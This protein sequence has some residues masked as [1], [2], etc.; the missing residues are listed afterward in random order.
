M[1][2]FP[3]E[4]EKNNRAA[5]N[6]ASRS[7]HAHRRDTPQGMWNLSGSIPRAPT[8]S[9]PPRVSL[10]LW[11]DGGCRPPIGL[12]SVLAPDGRLSHHGPGRSSTVP[13]MV[14]R[15]RGV[16]TNTFTLRLLAAPECTAA[17]ASEPAPL[18]SL[19]RH[20][21][22][23]FT[24]R[25]AERRCGHWRSLASRSDSRCRG[26][27]AGLWGYPSPWSPGSRP[28]A[29]PSGTG[30]LPESR[31]VSEKG[32][33]AALQRVMQNASAIAVARRSIL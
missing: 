27:A 33:G 20:A 30:P 2:I 8:D 22:G 4:G 1:R 29:R 14:V 3:N 15:L 6:Q 12:W 5:S 26:T 31:L 16:G 23:A 25:R 21:T 13:I 17:L 9:Q 28:R 7:S 11:V 19:G 10:A 18:G 24:G 32:L